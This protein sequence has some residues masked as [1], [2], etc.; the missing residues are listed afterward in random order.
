MLSS[1]STD[2]FVNRVYTKKE[3]TI[4]RPLFLNKVYLFGLFH[5][6]HGLFHYNTFY[7]ATTIGSFCTNK[8]QALF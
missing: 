4:S 7:C 3:G 6:S 2:E 5:H 8:V 1:I